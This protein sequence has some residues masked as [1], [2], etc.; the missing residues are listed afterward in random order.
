MRLAVFSDIHSNR[1]ALEACMNE[2]EK[3]GADLWLFLGDYVSD[4]ACPH[5]TM[6]RLYAA[7][8]AHDCRFMLGNR[9]E[10]LLGHHKNGSDWA[11]GQTTG[12]L[13]YTYE[14]LT[15]ADLAFFET[16]PLTDVLHIA[17][18]DPIRL[19]HGTPYK[20][21]VE[22]KPDNGRVAEVL[23]TV[24]EPVLL[25]GHSHTQFFER[26]GEKLYVNP[27]SVG[28][29]TTG[30]T[31]AEMAFLTW[32]GQNW[33]PELWHVP[34][35]IE[36]AISE[37]LA[38]GLMDRTSVWAHCIAKGLRT[39]RNYA[40]ECLTLAETLADGADITNEHLYKAAEQLGILE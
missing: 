17:G 35:D 8:N 3:R 9:E 28:V 16:L 38:E 18:T 12:S 25:S 24:Q 37:M 5:K 4:C 31:K 19:C 34:Y 22:L 23:Q 29:P 1:F 7:Q 27:G 11:Y 36:G 2:A 20:T 40:I 14:N 30:V 33:V 39:A 10:Y 26:V 32:N 15:A 6:E 13:L 21:R